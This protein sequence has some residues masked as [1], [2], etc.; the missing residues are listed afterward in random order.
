[1][2]DVNDSK[3]VFLAVPHVFFFVVVFFFFAEDAPQGLGSNVT[4]WLF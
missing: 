2:Y 4:L 1:M 3:L